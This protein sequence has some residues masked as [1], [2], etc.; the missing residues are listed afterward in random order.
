MRRKGL[1]ALAMRPATELTIDDATAAEL[2]VALRIALRKQS[3]MT[4]LEEWRKQRCR[5]HMSDRQ[6]LSGTS[7]AAETDSARNEKSRLKAGCSQDW[8]PHK[9]LWN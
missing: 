6:S 8:L 9:V 7:L 1:G 4:H 2:T 5:V 3:W